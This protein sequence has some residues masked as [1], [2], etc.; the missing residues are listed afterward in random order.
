MRSGARSRI[1]G[2]S[3]SR[4]IR[5]RPAAARSA[6][7][8]PSRIGSSGAGADRLSRRRAGQRLAEEGLAP[9]AQRAF[10]RE[11]GL[12]GRRL[13]S[14]RRQEPARG[15]A[16]PPRGS[17]RGARQHGRLRKQAPAA[18]RKP[19][20]P[21]LG[22]GERAHPRLPRRE[23]GDLPWPAARGALRRRR[24]AAP[25]PRLR[26]RLTRPAKG[27]PA[28]S[29]NGH[30]APKSQTQTDARRNANPDRRKP[31]KASPTSPS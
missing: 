19:A 2:S 16:V 10:R 5:P 8:G 28:N 20:S 3:T 11:T 18:A 22:R 25:E 23:P 14:D 31:S 6:C 21:S 27:V 15:D 17:R 4:P 9:H 13:R 1:W 24:T 30:S 12:S 29:R 7:S 26:R